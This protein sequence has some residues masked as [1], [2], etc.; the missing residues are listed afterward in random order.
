MERDEFSAA[1][2]KMKVNVEASMVN[3]IYDE[4]D[5]VGRCR[6]TPSNPC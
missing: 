6:F 3:T 5:M 4:A 1:C 2:D